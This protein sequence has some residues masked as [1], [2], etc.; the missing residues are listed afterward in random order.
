ML[1]W[2]SASPSSVVDSASMNQG[3]SD[4]DAKQKFF[5]IGVG[6]MRR[7]LGFQQKSTL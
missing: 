2:T 5:S 4:L 3:R 1:S 6:A 7:M